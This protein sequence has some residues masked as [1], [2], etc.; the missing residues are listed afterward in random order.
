MHWGVAD[1]V[2]E[3]DHCA[4]RDHVP[5]QVSVEEEAGHKIMEEHLIEVVLILVMGHMHVKALDTIPKVDE[6]KAQNA[7]GH[8]DEG[9]IFCGVYDVSAS[10]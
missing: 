6:T 7:W 9:E 8:L 5:D 1:V 10:S 2:K 4:E 3:R